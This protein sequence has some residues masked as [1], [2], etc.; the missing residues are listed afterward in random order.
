M[1]IVIGI[2]IGLLIGFV[3][4]KLMEAKTGGE[5]KTQ[6]IAKVQVLAAN[7][8]QDKLHHASE[9]K[10]MKDSHASE[11]Q[12]LKLKW[13]MNDCMLRNFDQRATSSGRRNSKTSSRR[14][15]G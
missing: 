15:S 6:L 11:V 7:I 4:G 8:E 9:M 10:G 1:E 13:R 12:S 5:E 3:V 14:C 2:I